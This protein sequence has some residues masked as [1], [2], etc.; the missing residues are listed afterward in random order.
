MRVY[1][2]WNGLSSLEALE[3]LLP[4]LFMES[5]DRLSAVY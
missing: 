3:L 1:K 4:V 2:A 5:M